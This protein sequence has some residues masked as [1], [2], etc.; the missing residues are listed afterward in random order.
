MRVGSASGSA[1]SLELEPSHL[2]GPLLASFGLLSGR[3]HCLHCPL[4]EE[5]SKSM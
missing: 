4:V 2:S 3:E 5:R 1:V